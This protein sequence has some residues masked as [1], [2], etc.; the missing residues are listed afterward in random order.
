MWREARQLRRVR[1][2]GGGGCEERA[3]VGLGALPAA[4]DRIRGVAEAAA[5]WLQIAAVQVLPCDLG[6]CG[7]LGRGGS[8]AG[9]GRSCQQREHHDPHSEAVRDASVRMREGAA[10]GRGLQCFSEPRSTGFWS[11]AYP[12]SPAGHCAARGSQAHHRPDRTP[13]PAG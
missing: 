3:A 11:V 1:S 13:S 7:A 5:K 12:L 10:A 2:L 6:F 9:G 8:A 4:V